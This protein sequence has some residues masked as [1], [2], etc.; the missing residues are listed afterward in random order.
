MRFGKIAAV[1]EPP[2]ANQSA[3]VPQPTGE[4]FHL[5]Y[6]SCVCVT[7]NIFIHLR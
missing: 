1:S 6:V 3:F 4:K 7:K 2:K 5:S